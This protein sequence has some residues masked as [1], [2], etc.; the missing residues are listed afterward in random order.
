MRDRDDST[1]KDKSEI[2]PVYVETNLEDSDSS[3][4]ALE[5]EEKEPI[6]FETPEVR[7]STRERRS[8]VWHLDYV[9]KINVAYCLLTED[10]K[11]LTFHQALNNSDVALL[12]TTM[13]E[14]IEALYKNKT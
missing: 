4:A 1:I 5:H 9:T 10:G 13:Q 12:M 11:P 8:P 14:E 6:E 3:E 2:V 7:R